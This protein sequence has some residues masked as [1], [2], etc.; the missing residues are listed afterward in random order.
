MRAVRKPP[1]V[2]RLGTP[3][4]P[5]VPENITLTAVLRCGLA[6]CTLLAEGEEVRFQALVA[7]V[8]HVDRLACC[9]DRSIGWSQLV[10]TRVSML[11]SNYGMLHFTSQS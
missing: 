10:M 1:F 7:W 5:L 8:T 9:T 6:W 3:Q 2:V 4:R 11:Q